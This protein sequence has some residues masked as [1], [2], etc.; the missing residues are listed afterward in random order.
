MQVQLIK[1]KYSDC[2]T[3][4]DL[5][6]ALTNEGYDIF[7]WQDS[8]GAYYAPHKHPHDEFIAVSSGSIIFKIAG[9]DYELNQGD[10]L[11]LPQGTVHEAENKGIATVRY[12]ICTRD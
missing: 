3:E 9:N 1:D 12:F 7:S 11:I 6:Q 10:L 2:K 4:N 8:P 5:K